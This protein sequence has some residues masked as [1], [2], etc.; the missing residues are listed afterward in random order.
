MP[1]QLRVKTKNHKQL[2][3]WLSQAYFSA[4]S[5]KNF[6]FTSVAVFGFRSK[7][8]IVNLVTLYWWPLAVSVSMCGPRSRS[9][10]CKRSNAF[11]CHALRS[12]S[13]I[14]RQGPRPQSS[15]L[16]TQE[17]HLGLGAWEMGRE[18]ETKEKKTWI[19]SLFSEHE[20]FSFSSRSVDKGMHPESLSVSL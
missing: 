4:Q 13:K 9:I 7:K 8:K 14:E 16:T 1:V 10:N 19:S 15:L 3:E 6:W 17:I 12:S 18:K 5:P 11:L 2:P 20:E